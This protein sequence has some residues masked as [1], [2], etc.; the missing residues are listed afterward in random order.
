MSTLRTNGSDA[1]IISGL[2]SPQ[3]HN[4]I[5]FLTADVAIN[6]CNH[7]QMQAG[8]KKSFMHLPA[9]L[10][11][12]VYNELLLAR[13]DIA[14]NLRSAIGS[15]AQDHQSIPNKTAPWAQKIETVQT[16]QARTTI[17]TCNK[18]LTRC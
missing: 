9:E 18:Y 16:I 1:K 3:N 11:L 14:L 2:S 13:A 10:R 5:A 4:D 17:G 8:V 7:D 15:T 6:A 12:L